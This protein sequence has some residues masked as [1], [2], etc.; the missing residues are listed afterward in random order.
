MGREGEG[1]G[2]R[3]THEAR[4]SALVGGVHSI[5]A[6]AMRGMDRPQTSTSSFVLIREGTIERTSRTPNIIGKLASPK[7]ICGTANFVVWS[8]D[9]GPPKKRS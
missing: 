3:V 9:I 4:H 7:S 5:S 1:G 2:L 8:S 6:Q